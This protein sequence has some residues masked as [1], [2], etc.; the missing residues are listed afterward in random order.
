MSQSSHITTAIL[1][2]QDGT[3]LDDDLIPTNNTEAAPSPHLHIISMLNTFNPD[4]I[5]ESGA[6]PG[7]VLR[8]DWLSASLAEGL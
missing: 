1:N 8:N 5:W 4:L 7:N 6:A 2:I 3:V